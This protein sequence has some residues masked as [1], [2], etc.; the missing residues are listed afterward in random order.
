[1]PILF[2]SSKKAEKDDVKNYRLIS[3][4]SLVSKMAECCVINQIFEFIASVIYHL[5]HG[6]VKAGMVNCY[7]IIVHSSSCN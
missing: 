6:F 7:S 1:M 5:Q 2:P 3:L 4:L